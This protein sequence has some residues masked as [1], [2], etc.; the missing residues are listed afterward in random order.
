MV[1]EIGRGDREGEKGAIEERECVTVRLR[2]DGSAG[3]QLAG[4]PENVC[5]D[6]AAVSYKFSF[7]NFSVVLFY[8][9]SSSL[10]KLCILIDF[11][12]YVI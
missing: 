12:F 10:F 6:V 3:S 9:I 8:F 1:V 5:S 7:P 11:V 2:G 4:G